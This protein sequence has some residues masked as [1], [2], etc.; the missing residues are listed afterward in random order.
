MES[1]IWHNLTTEQHH[2]IESKSW[3]FAWQ[4]KMFFYFFNFVSMQDDGWSLNLLWKLFHD[5]CKSNHGMLCWMLSCSITP[6]SW[7]PLDCSLGILCPWDFSDKNTGVGCHFPLWGS[8][9]P[10]DWTRVFRVFCIAGGLFTC[11]AIGEAKLCILYTLN[12]YSDV[13]Q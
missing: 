2:H 7:D 13:C 11:W 8:A 5:V 12:L 1:Q 3:Q 4:G 10:K 6:D 9:R